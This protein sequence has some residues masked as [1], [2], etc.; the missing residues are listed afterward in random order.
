MYLNT[1]L[2]SPEYIRIHIT[3][4]PDE[5]LED[6]NINNEYIDENGFV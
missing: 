5:I 4:I 1:V 2:D 3:M 6:Y